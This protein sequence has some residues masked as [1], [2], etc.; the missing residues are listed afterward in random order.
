MPKHN[1]AVPRNHF[2]KDWQRFVK[3]WFNQP[4]RAE[5]RRISRRDKAARVAPR[6][7]STLKP[8]VR[9][10]TAKYNRRVRQGKGFTID[11][12]RAAGINPKSAPG[13][14]IAVDKRRKNRS[15]ES[16]QRVSNLIFSTFLYIIQYIMY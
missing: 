2:R 4:A 6:P 10:Q 3:T 8:I 16:L 14:G 1:N 7:V 12:L 9:C 13:I 11:E 5:R 15:E